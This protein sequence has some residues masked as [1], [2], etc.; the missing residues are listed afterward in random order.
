MLANIEMIKKHM[1][2]YTR[3]H[4]VP[5]IVDFTKRIKEYLCGKEHDSIEPQKYAMRENTI[6]SMKRWKIRERQEIRGKQ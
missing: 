2:I 5:N 6:E 3:S 1:I 4:I